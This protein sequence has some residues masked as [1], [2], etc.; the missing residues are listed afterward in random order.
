METVTSI[1]LFVV[2][3]ALVIYGADWFTKGASSIARRFG[4]SE[5]VI[6]LTIVA[7]G[8]SLPELVIST[9]AALQG[10]SG[11]ALGNVIGSNIFNSLVILGVTAMITP[12]AFN[13]KMLT[14]EI[15]FNLLASVA[16]LLVSGG[17]LYEML[18]A[19]TSGDVSNGYIT[20]TG[21]LIL[22]CFLMVF[23]RYTFSVAKD[24]DVEADDS[25]TEKP[26]SIKM[27]VLLIVGGLASLIIGGKMFV[28]GASSIASILGVP[29]AIIGVTIVAMGTS[30]PELAVSVSA[31]RKGSVGIAL[32]NVLGSNILNVFFIM[33]VCSTISP[34]SLSGFDS[35]NYFVL[36]LSSLIIYIVA[37]FFGKATITRIEGAVLL[38]IY[39]AYTAYLIV[40]I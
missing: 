23:M 19:E 29:E 5:L 4:I 2:G 21:G 35:I 12:I 15:P 3:V 9:S 11:I 6:G 8:T 18:G 37:K 26:V 32:G 20:R 36:L 27:I 22:L 38:L 40:N 25:A 34:V 14:R 28:S 1:I 33:G 24:G 31:A 10:G 16:L 39:I 30:L 17:M 13:P 7:L